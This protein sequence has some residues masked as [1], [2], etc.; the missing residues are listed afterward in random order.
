M[1]QT[2]AIVRP[3]EVVRDKRAQELE[4]RHR[5]SPPQRL[6]VLLS[7]HPPCT[8]PPLPSQSHQALLCR[9]KTYIF[10]GSRL[11]M[12]PNELGLLEA[13]T[14]QCAQYHKHW[15]EMTRVLIC[16]SCLYIKPIQWFVCVPFFKST[17]LIFFF[18]YLGILYRRHRRPCKIRPAQMFFFPRQAPW[19]IGNPSKKLFIVMRCQDFLSP[20]RC[21]HY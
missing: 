5:L 16:C 4:P 13:M 3:H 10:P 21:W 20:P 17:C 1:L 15:G 18:F 11:E 9:T 8:P 7:G 19:D 14:F 6:V 2:A 12:M